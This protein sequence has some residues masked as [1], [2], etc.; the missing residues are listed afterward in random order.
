MVLA[1][2][3]MISSNELLS[4]IPLFDS[5][6]LESINSR[7]SNG[8]F[9]VMSNST[10]RS[11]ESRPKGTRNGNSGFWKF[12]YYWLILTFGMILSVKS[13]QSEP[14][15]A[16]MSRTEPNDPNWTEANR[17]EPSRDEPTCFDSLRQ[18]F[19]KLKRSESN[20]LC[21][22]KKERV[23]SQVDSFFKSSRTEP[24]WACSIF[25]ISA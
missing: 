14:N 19:L 7:T 3:L 2:S 16:A 15:R 24:R 20:R 10:S 9:G 21:I 13:M 17:V 1:H 5:E 4:Q 25:G 23:N 8:M 18:L 11:S 6:Y 12:L 22:S